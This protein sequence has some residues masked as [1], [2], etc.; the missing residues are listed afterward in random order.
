[1]G[2]AQPQTHQATTYQ[3]ESVRDCIKEAWPLLLAHWG[4]VAHYPDIPL[5]PDDAA[6]FELEDAGFLRVFTVRREGEL[7]GYAVFLVGPN[8]HYR[9]SLQAKQD[10]LFLL[11]VYRGSRIGYKF[12]KYCDDQLRDES[13]QVVY[14]HV[15]P[16]VDFGPLLK[17]IGYEFTETIYGRRLDLWPPRAS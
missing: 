11:P 2:L 15:K 6:Y 12:I 17:H 8:P 9:T 14:H 3:R 16:K 7:I 10:I 13:V 5:D 4:E 1:M